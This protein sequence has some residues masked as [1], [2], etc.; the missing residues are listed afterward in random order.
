MLGA[1][2][3]QMGTA[4]LL[5]DEVALPTLYRQALEQAGDESTAITNVFTG[6]PARAIVN[7]AVREIGP[8][9]ADAPPFPLAGLPLA[10][11]RAHSESAGSNDFTPLW[12]G[13]SANL[14]KALPAAEITRRTAASALDMM[15]TRRRSNR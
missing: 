12:S 3:V 6:R 5:S 14:A 4:Y 9:S 11:L 13:Q 8:I 15:T 10:P 7:R 2:A 1:S